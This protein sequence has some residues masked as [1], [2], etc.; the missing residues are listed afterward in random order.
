MESRLRL[1]EH[2]GHE[3]PRERGSMVIDAIQGLATTLKPRI[4]QV[5]RSDAVVEVKNFIGSVRMSDGTVLEVEPKVPV[6][7]RWAHAVVQLLREDSRISVTGSQQARPGTR[8]RDCPW[9]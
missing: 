9:P 8:R 3:L 2:E 6:D 5:S 1:R 4:A 7:G